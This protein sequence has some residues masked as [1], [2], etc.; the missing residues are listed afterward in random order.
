MLPKRLA[1]GR[2]PGLGYR[3][4]TQANPKPDPAAGLRPQ[5]QTE[6]R[7]EVL[8]AAFRPRS[9]RSPGHRPQAQTSPES[10]WTDQG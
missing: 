5:A 7:Q 10:G 4:Q 3:P 6:S 9:T 1:V 2:T 8:S